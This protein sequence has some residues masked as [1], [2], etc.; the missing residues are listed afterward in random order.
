MHLLLIIVLHVVYLSK[1]S[2]M[3]LSHE[4]SLLQEKSQ[5]YEE[6]KSRYQEQLVQARANSSKELHE[7]RIQLADVTDKMAAANSNANRKEEENLALRYLQ[8]IC[9]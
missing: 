1:K 3:I 9:L 7:L 6:L 5:E 8:W 4:R 2:K